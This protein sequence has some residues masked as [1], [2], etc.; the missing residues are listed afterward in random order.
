MSLDTELAAT[1]VSWGERRWAVALHVAAAEVRNQDLDDFDGAAAGLVAARAQVGDDP[2]FARAEQ[3][4]AFRKNEHAQVID[5]VGSLSDAFE[6]LPIEFAYM[7]REGAI[8]ASALDRHGL[9]ADWFGLADRRLQRAELLPALAIGLAADRAAATVRSGNMPTAIAAMTAVLDRLSALAPESGSQARFVHRIVRHALLWFADQAGEAGMK[10]AGEPPALPPGAC[11]NPDPHPDIS[12][13]TLHALDF[14]W[15]VLA[16]A[17]LLAGCPEAVPPLSSRLT[18]GPLPP[19]E[20]TY[21]RRRLDLMLSRADPERFMEALA[22][23]VAAMEALPATMAKFASIDPAQWTHGD[24][25]VPDLADPWS[26]KYVKPWLMVFRLSAALQLRPDATSDLRSRL[27]A[28]ADLARHATDPT[29]FPS[30]AP[31]PPGSRSL[32]DC[33]GM[34][35]RED[36]DGV[37]LVECCV[38]VGEWLGAAGNYPEVT[39]RFVAWA[40]RAWLR[41]AAEQRFRLRS[42]RVSAAAISE[43]ASRPGDDLPLLATVTL[44]ALQGVPLTLPPSYLRWLREKASSPGPSAGPSA[45]IGSASAYTKERGS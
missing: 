31:N 6:K 43:A 21:R 42:P 11:S 45:G 28:S 9:A 26:D 29:L 37:E 33:V 36:L 23:G 34:C 27:A 35:G 17:A 15:Y 13:S 44:A 10:V 1:A 8:S 40:K 20:I 2:W 5:L 18:K 7:L 4:M 19:L 38:R 14:A 16:D 22:G 3:K 25:P 32:A 41:I 30:I 39:R 24:L 12:G